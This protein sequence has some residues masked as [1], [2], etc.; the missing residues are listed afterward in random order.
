MTIGHTFQWQRLTELVTRFYQAEETTAAKK[1][2]DD[3]PETQSAK[4]QPCK[5]EKTRRY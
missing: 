3:L 2:A 5:N 4:N 1:H